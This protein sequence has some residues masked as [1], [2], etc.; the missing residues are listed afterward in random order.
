MKDTLSIK[1]PSNP[2]YTVLVRLLASGIGRQLN[3]PEDE[4]EDLKLVLSEACKLKLD[5]GPA[6]LDFNIDISNS[7]IDIGIASFL[8]SSMDSGSDETKWSLDLISSLMDKVEFQ[9]AGDNGT[10]VLKLRKN[11]SPVPYAR[12]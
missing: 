9:N 8:K 7:Y 2:K 11:L 12:L 10:H 6:P 4:V 3:L 1:I 5:E